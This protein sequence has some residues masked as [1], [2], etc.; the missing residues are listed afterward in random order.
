MSVPVAPAIPESLET[1]EILEALG[2]P[3]VSTDLVQILVRARVLVLV[4]TAA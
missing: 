4:Q 2:V 3:E 1:L